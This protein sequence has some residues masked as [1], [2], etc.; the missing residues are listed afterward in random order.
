MVFKLNIFYRLSH[1]QTTASAET[2]MTTP[3][4]IEKRAKGKNSTNHNHYF[5]EKTSPKR[6]SNY[7]ITVSGAILFYFCS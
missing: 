2:K 1:I 4:L 7:S 5:K 3:K 6:E